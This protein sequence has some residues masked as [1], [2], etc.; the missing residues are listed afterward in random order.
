MAQSGRAKPR[1]SGRRFLLDGGTPRKSI[2]SHTNQPP[3]GIGIVRRIR[4]T[5]RGIALRIRSGAVSLIQPDRS[6]PVRCAP[7]PSWRPASTSSSRRTTRTPASIT[8]CAAPFRHCRPDCARPHPTAS[9]IP[10]CWACPAMRARVQARRRSLF[11]SARPS[12]SRPR[13][14]VRWRTRPPPKRS[15]PCSTP[16][17]RRRSWQTRPRWRRPLTPRFAKTRS[18]EPPVR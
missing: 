6:I 14:C 9:A 13:H 15:R 11:S 3:S 18:A 17:S 8:I 10:P 12:P 5:W 4:T 1:Y 2:E 7:A 16:T